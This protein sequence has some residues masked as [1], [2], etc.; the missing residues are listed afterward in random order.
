MDER[1][2]AGKQRKYD[3]SEGARA[4]C[5]AIIHRVVSLLARQLPGRPDRFGHRQCSHKISIYLGLELPLGGQDSKPSVPNSTILFLR[6]A[7]EY[8]PN[9]KRMGRL[10]PSIS[11]PFAQQPGTPEPPGI[12]PQPP[13][14]PTAPP[15]YEDPPRPIP[16]PRPNEPPVIDD[17]PPTSERRTFSRGQTGKPAQTTGAT[18]GW[19]PTQRCFLVMDR[20]S[21]YRDLARHARELAEASWQDFGRNTLPLGA[22]V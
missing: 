18:W 4:R 6:I 1:I 3:P 8:R 15:P 19:F 16:I 22:R 9:Y 12:P 21:H 5:P 13:P 14:D 7:S 10:H 17:L 2:G 11:V 20:A